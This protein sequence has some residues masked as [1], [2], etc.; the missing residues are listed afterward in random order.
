MSPKQS[1]TNVVE[2][3]T[4]VADLLANRL[5][6]LVLADALSNEGAKDLIKILGVHPR[7]PGSSHAAQVHKLSTGLL[8]CRPL[9]TDTLQIPVMGFCYAG[10]V[11]VVSTSSAN[12]HSL[13]D[14]HSCQL[15]SHLLCQ[16]LGS[17]LQ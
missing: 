3:L 5:K 13:I 12:R 15:V 11:Q 16:K 17:F 14:R 1:V 7:H 8:C 4:H 9:S 2:W 6:K 10:K